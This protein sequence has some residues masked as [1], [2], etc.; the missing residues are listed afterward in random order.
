MPSAVADHSLSSSVNGEKAVPAA[1]WSMR[2]CAAAAS[3]SGSRAP[4]RSG[5]LESTATARS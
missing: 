4:S 2:A 1:W 5:A 3:Y